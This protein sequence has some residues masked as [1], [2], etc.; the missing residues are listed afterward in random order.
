MYVYGIFIFLR[1][2]RS[3]YI[4]YGKCGIFNGHDAMISHCLILLAD[5]PRKAAQPFVVEPLG[6][7]MDSSGTWK[8][9][10]EMRG[11]LAINGCYKWM[12][13]SSQMVG[14]WHGVCRA[15]SSLPMKI[16]FP[17]LLGHPSF[18]VPYGFSINEGTQNRW[19]IMENPI[20]VD[21]LGVP[22]F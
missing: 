4:E 7:F 14:L 18:G 6:T 9:P 1:V 10:S 13:K 15:T 8:W 11:K 22:L 16:Q 20:K 5:L 12:E 2:T 21:D 17:L 3:L 19:F